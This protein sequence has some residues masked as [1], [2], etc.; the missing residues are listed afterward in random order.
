M[1]IQAISSSNEAMSTQATQNSGIIT[2]DDFFKL[3]V[4]QIQNQD[5]TDPMDPAQTI[6]QMAQVSASQASVEVKDAVS[7]IGAQNQIALAN[8]MIGKYVKYNS[9]DGDVEA[10]ARVDAVMMRNDGL[11]V[12]VNGEEISPANIT[13]ISDTQEQFQS[14]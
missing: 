9:G 11:K 8:S 2:S 7:Q 12:V 1:D 3:L 5:P 13:A 10:L 14:S 4:A 6:T